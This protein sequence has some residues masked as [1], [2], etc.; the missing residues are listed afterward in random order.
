MYTFVID[1]GSTVSVAELVVM[2]SHS[3]HK[4]SLLSE[5]ENESRNLRQCN[6]VVYDV[7]IE[8]NEPFPQKSATV[9]EKLC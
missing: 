4:I 9:I 5:K 8:D 1:N 7:W 2:L 3:L 6:I